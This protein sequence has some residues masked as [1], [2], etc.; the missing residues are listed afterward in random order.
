MCFLAGYI[1]VKITYHYLVQYIYHILLKQTLIYPII[2]LRDHASIYHCILT[3]YD[4]SSRCA[5]M[6]QQLHFLT[7]SHFCCVPIQDLEN[8]I[9]FVTKS[10]HPPIKTFISLFIRTIAQRKLASTSTSYSLWA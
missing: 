4:E 6:R 1:C 9:T 10:D 2:M 8:F 5:H 3:L 7:S